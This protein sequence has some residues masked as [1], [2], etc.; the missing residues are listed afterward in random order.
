MP[1]FHYQAL[2]AGNRTEKGV[3]QADT[4]RAARAALRDR[5]LTPLKVALVE[6]DSG[7]GT[8]LSATAQVLLTRQLATLFSAGLPLDEVLAA[9]AEGADGAMRTITLA[10]RARVMEG[11]S[12]AL[13]LAEFPATFSPLYRASVAAGEQAGRLGVVLS[14]LAAHLESRDAMRRRVIAALAYPV[15]LLF[16]ALLVVSGLMLYVVPEVTGV[17]VRNGQSLPWATRTLL[18]ISAG[19]QSNVWWLLPAVLAVFAGLIA[20]WRRPAF[21]RWRHRRWLRIPLLSQLLIALDSARYARTLAM[22]GASAVPL[23]DAMSLANATVAN[24]ELRDALAQVAARVREGVPLAQALTGTG[25]FP[26]L[27]V[28]LIASGERAGR[29][30]AMLDEAAAQL[31]R[32][33]DMVLSVLMAALGPVVIILVGGLVLFIVLAI[34]LPI[35]QLNQLVR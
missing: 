9:A 35:F 34:L 10:L 29:L 3:L 20:S 6:A 4:P 32:E 33:L 23:L 14:Q 15:L 2:S 13:A 1:A 28:R 5:G 21:I 16:F 24:L 18:A 17:F 22:L 31:E 30:D 12:L 19:L 27:A 11:S 7:H 8:R 25:W 26:P